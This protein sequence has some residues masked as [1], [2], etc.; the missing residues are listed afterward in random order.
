MSDVWDAHV[1]ASGYVA[2][3]RDGTAADIQALVGRLLVD[4]GVAGVRRL[5]TPGE[6]M[7]RS[8]PLAERVAS[9]SLPPLESE[10]SVL[11]VRH[12]ASSGDVE[13]TVRVTC[14][15]GAGWLTIGPTLPSELV[16]VAQSAAH[17]SGLRLAVAGEA[18]TDTILEGPVDTIEG[19]LPL[20]VEP[21]LRAQPKWVQVSSLADGLSPGWPARLER[22]AAS[23]AVVVPLLLRV[24]RSSL[25]E[26]AA[27]AAGIQELVGILP[28]H[29][30]LLS[31]QSAGGARFAKRHLK[32]HLGVPILDRGARKR[33]AEGWERVQDGLRQVA[34]LGRRL[35]GGSGAPAMGLCPGYAIHEERHLWEDAGI[36]ESVIAQAFG[37]TAKA[38]CTTPSSA[39]AAT[40]EGVR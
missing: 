38:V 3:P 25:L 19:L 32:E 24:R 35:A 22:I 33:F 5:G 40:S 27:R 9:W 17:D 2:S 37:P 13:R 21:E 26:E 1:N 31:A 11:A 30:Y 7:P 8:G 4:H 16:K 20:L 36:E 28:Y 15:E 39:A 10:H 29:Q 12:C 14:A 6:L 34:A 23:Q 18:A